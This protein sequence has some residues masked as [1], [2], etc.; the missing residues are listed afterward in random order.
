MS[1]VPASRLAEVCGKTSSAI[2]KWAKRKGL[3][4]HKTLESSENHYL[5]SSLPR[6][7]Q[8]A[9][10]RQELDQAIAGCVADSCPTQ[11]ECE[12]A[13]VRLNSAKEYNSR[14]VLARLEVIKAYRAMEVKRHGEKKEALRQEF[15]RLFQ[16]RRLGLAEEVHEAI[17]KLS[18]S[19]IKLWLRKFEKEGA[20][21]LVDNFGTTKPHALSEEQQRFILG[22][23]ARNPQ[24]RPMRVY[25]YLI[26]EFGKQKVPCKSTIYNQMRRWKKEN[27]SAYCFLLSPDDWKNRYQPAFGDMAAAAT[28]VNAIW[29]LD[30]TPADLLC[31]DGKRYTLIGVIDVFSRRLKILVA[32]TSSSGGI[33]VVLRQAMLTW[34]VPDAVRLDNGQDYQAKRIA[35]ACA[36]LE[37]EQ[38]T[39]PP[40]TPEGKPFIERGFGTLSHLFEELPGYT[41]HNV[42]ERQQIR[43]RRSFAERLMKKGET[44]EVPLTAEQLQ[45]AINRWLAAAYEQREHKSLKGS[46]AAKAASCAKPIRRIQDERALDILLAEGGTRVVQKKGIAWAGTVFQSLALAAHVG[47][48]VQLKVDHAE[49]SRLWVFSQDGAFICEARDYALEGIS[50]AEAAEAKR[51]AKRHLREQR[52]GLQALAKDLPDNPMLDRLDKLEQAPGRVTPLKRSEGVELESLRQAGLAAAAGAQEQ[53]LGELGDHDGGEVHVF[54]YA[55]ERYDFLLAESAARELTA[56]EVEWLAWFKTTDEYLMLYGD[57]NEAAG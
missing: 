27:H 3:D 25:E 43:A 44:I 54:Q 11:A 29:E 46:P 23:I 50:V 38:I 47:S 24:V 33:A 57:T 13:M 37:I 35:M 39:L 17:P 56:E 41:G 6:D 48:I 34:G 9:L 12:A 19:S 18:S 28:H 14:K 2:R 8:A 21:G 15:C 4:V 1:L 10:Q 7:I 22:H 5:R 42:A 30:S 55:W 52:K 20:A 49:A 51:Q 53:S 31:A 45:D 32:P 36:S 40:F 26:Q 16:E